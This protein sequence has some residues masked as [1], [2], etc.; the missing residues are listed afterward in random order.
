[1]HIFYSG[2]KSALCSNI[3]SSQGCFDELGGIWDE[4]A[5]SVSFS[6]KTA[7]EETREKALYC[8]MKQ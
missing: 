5:I 8:V 4:W 1:M 3:K 6:F 2:K 7:E